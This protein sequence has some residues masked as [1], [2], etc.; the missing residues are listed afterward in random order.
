MITIFTL[1]NYQGELFF[2]A[3]N[4]SNAV[5]NKISLGDLHHPLSRAGLY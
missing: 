5:K 4:I 2:L 1:T 3:Q